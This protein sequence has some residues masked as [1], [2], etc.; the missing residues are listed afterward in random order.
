[1]LAD[2]D[3]LGWTVI[4]YSC[5][6]SLSIES[7]KLLLDFCLKHGDIKNIL[8]QRD[9]EGKSCIDHAIHGELVTDAF[10]LLIAHFPSNESFQSICGAEREASTNSFE[11]VATKEVNALLQDPDCWKK[12]REWAHV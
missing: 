11:P 8:E 9:N 3:A 12:C 5:H 6:W 10:K 7:L 4:M 1:M 2:H